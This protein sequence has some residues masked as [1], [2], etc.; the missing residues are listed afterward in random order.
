[1]LQISCDLLLK[2]KKK[3]ISHFSGISYDNVES[4]SLTRELLRIVLVGGY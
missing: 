2:K 4:N 3:V 1:M